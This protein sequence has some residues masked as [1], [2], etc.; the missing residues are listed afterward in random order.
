MRLPLPLPALA[1]SLLATALA[2]QQPSARA[3]AVVTGRVYDSL[4]ARPLEGA[5]VQLVTRDDAGAGVRS[6]RTTDDG[7]FTIPGVAA[8][9]FMLGFLHP[10][11]DSLGIEAPLRAIEVGMGDTVRVELALPSSRGVRLTLCGPGAAGEPPAALVGV[12]RDAGDRSPVAGAVVQATWLEYDIVPRAVSRRR[13]VAADTS[14]IDGRFALCDVPRGGSLALRALRAADSTA[15]VEFQVPA[16]GLLRRD[17][18]LGASRGTFARVER[19]ERRAPRRDERA[20]PEAAIDSVPIRVGDGRLRGRVRAAAG[21][22]PLDGV[23]VEI[24]HGAATRTSPRG[25]WSLSGLPT[26][27]G[28]LLVRRVGFYPVRLP[29]DVVADAPD[30]NVALAEFEAMLDTIRVN[31]S[32]WRV[33][34]TG[35]DERRRTGAGRYITTADMLATPVIFT[36]DVFLRIPGMRVDRTT[37]GDRRLS[38][39]GAFGRCAPQVYVDGMRMLNLGADDIDAFVSPD[40]VA[41]IEVYSGAFVPAQFQEGLGGCGSIVIW[42]KPGENPARRWSA[43]R[44]AVQ[45]TAALLVGAGL[46]VLFARH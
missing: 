25:E 10:V 20:A 8:G 1:F 32:R 24:E 13:A 30:V 34:E 31:A 39:R 26:G 11:L 6:V 21:G 22:R 29:V 7:R 28:N 36:S 2:A 33:Q 4:A 42:T 16:T 3:A 45:A 9:R 23:V 41:G 44:R 46:G 14:G 43:R 12:V 38:M 15:I 5:T 35:F 37:L 17:L 19:V 40:E 27:T 18:F